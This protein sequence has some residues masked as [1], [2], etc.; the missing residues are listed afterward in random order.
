[1]QASQNTQILLGKTGYL[2]CTVVENVIRFVSRNEELN[3]KLQ[4]VFVGRASEFAPRLTNWG[5]LAPSVLFTRNDLSR[6]TVI[7]FPNIST[8]S[9]RTHKQDRKQARDQFSHTQQKKAIKL[10]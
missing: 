7:K 5:Q 3:F 8:H 9:M 1:M 6:N 2:S 10:T 4:I